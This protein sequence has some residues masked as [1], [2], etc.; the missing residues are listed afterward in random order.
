MFCCG[1]SLV[2]EILFITFFSILGVQFFGQKF[3]KCMVD[4]EKAEH[5]DIANK[6]QCI[7]MYGQEAWQ[8]SKINFDSSIMAFFALYQVV[9]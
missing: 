7:S 8:N 3:W 6:T 1:A 2:L 9:N 5:S 4:G